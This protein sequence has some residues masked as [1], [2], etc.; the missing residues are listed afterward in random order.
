MSE[1]SAM[2]SPESIRLWLRAI[3]VGAVVGI[4]VLVGVGVIYLANSVRPAQQS[5]DLLVECITPPNLRTP[6][7]RHPPASDCYVRSRAEQ[8]ELLG[9][10][11]G[12]INTV[13]VAA[14]AC[15]AAHPG[16][17]AATLR[18]TRAAVNHP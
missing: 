5:R 15:G 3:L 8:G 4:L 12:P 2:P 7:V 16:D 6:P 17:V 10:P 1:L 14:A 9:E 18:C 11:K 13:A